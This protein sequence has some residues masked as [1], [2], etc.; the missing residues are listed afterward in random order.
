MIVKTMNVIEVA[1]ERE[2]NLE[3]SVVYR[4]SKRLEFRRI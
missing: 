2:K 1:L 4:V 3:D